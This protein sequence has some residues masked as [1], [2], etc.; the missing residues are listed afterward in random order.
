MIRRIVILIVILLSVCFAYGD[1]YTVRNQGKELSCSYFATATYLDCVGYDVSCPSRGFRT[2][3][4]DYPD[5]FAYYAKEVDGLTA[6][7][8]HTADIDFQCY[9]RR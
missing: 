9:P 3:G 1:E 5:A 4:G 7:K 2:N 8:I 6:S